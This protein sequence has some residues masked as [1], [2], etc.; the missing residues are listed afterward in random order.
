[1][2]TEKPLYNSK[3]T[4]SK[5]RSQNSLTRSL[6]HSIAMQLQDLELN[7][8]SSS[9]QLQ[10][11]ASLNP[12]LSGDETLLLSYYKRVRATWSNSAI[13]NLQRST[14]LKLTNNLN[15]CKF[16][17]EAAKQELHFVAQ[18]VAVN[19]RYLETE[20]LSVSSYQMESERNPTHSSLI[21]LLPTEKNNSLTYGSSELNR[22]SSLLS[23][24]KVTEKQQ[25]VI[26]T[27]ESY[28]HQLEIAQNKIKELE[29]QLVRQEEQL[30]QQQEQLDKSENFS[31]LLLTNRLLPAGPPLNGLQD[32]LPHKINNKQQQQ[33][34]EI[35]DPLNKV[36]I[37]LNLPCTT[38]RCVLR[39]ST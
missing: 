23:T 35:F 30:E 18:E 7:E 19:A 32:Y 5:L 31:L 24:T 13:K 36:S 26:E 14:G 16:A 4:R 39:Y 37:T 8:Q 38:S 2:G 27:K 21:L 28:Q 33:Q 34:Q 3:F 15:R 1:M 22:S 29:S 11:L 12:C 25:Q 9:R 10:I 17:I 20:Q 6:A